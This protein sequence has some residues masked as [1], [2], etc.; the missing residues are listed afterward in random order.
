MQNTLTYQL[1]TFIQLNYNN[2]TSQFPATKHFN[3]QYL[4]T[5]IYNI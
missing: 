2:K 5:S 3:L 4:N 1:T